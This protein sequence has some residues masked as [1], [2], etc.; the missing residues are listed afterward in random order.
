MA[1]ETEK[2]KDPT[3]CYTPV[4][5]VSYPSLDKPSSYEGKEGGFEITLLLDKKKC[6][7]TK[8]KKACEAALQKKWPDKTK[9]PKNLRMPF[10]DGDE[11]E[12]KPGYEGMTYIKATSKVKP[13]IMSYPDK[14][15]LEPSDAYAGCYARASVR[16]F[17]YDTKGNRGVSFMLQNVQ[18]IK[19]GERFNGRKSGANDFEDA[20]EIDEEFLE[21]DSEDDPDSYSGDEDEDGNMFS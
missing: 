4:G 19:D 9:R 6:D 1:K 2:V 12:D 8:M 15:H 10:R 20:E 13:D 18:K 11:K 7:L 5:R 14:D 21:V 17:A 3:S 16:A